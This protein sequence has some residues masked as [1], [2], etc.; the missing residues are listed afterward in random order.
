MKENMSLRPGFDAA[1]FDDPRGVSPAAGSDGS[2]EDGAKVRGGFWRLA[3]R[4]LGQC[5]SA[6]V[7]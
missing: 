5:L 6:R 3:L 4:R 2:D 1:R 7:S